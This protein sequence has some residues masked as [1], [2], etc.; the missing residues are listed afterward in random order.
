MQ[1]DSSAAAIEPPKQ[2]IKEG[3]YMPQE[4]MVLAQSDSLRI[5]TITEDPTNTQPPKLTLKTEFALNDQVLDILCI[6][7]ESM[8][9]SESLLA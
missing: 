9:R 2:E 3:K 5:F 1:I 8:H 4:N 7:A 6:P